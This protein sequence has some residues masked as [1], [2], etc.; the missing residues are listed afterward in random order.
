M[1]KLLN[2]IGY[3][4]VEP[5]RI[6]ARKKGGVLAD[7]PVS[8]DLMKTLESIENGIFLAWDAA[9]GFEGNLKKGELVYPTAESTIIGL[10]YSEVSLYDEYHSN[11]DFALFTKNPTL[12]H[13]R[14]APIYAVNA[15]DTAVE[16]VIPRLLF[17]SVGDVYTTNMVETADGNLPAVGTK[18]QLNASGVLSTETEGAL[19][20]ITAVVAQATTMADGQPAVKLVIQA[21]K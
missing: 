3:G 4:Q 20:L 21:V 12:G 18:L 7:V 16:T 19:D 11:K 10:V 14:Q 13:V 6:Q 17:P 8:A 9:V 1:A 15:K 2:K 5:N